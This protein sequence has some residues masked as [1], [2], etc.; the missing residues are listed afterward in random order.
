M[1]SDQLL[2]LLLTAV[3]MGTTLLLG[4][5]VISV[6]T[7]KMGELLL[8]IGVLRGSVQEMQRDLAEIVRIADRTSIGLQELSGFGL[9]FRQ[10]EREQLRLS[11]KLDM[12]SK[13]TD[14]LAGVLQLRDEVEREHQDEFKEIVEVSR[15][16][17]E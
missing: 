3:T 17:Q 9:Y 8:E 1:Q 5:F 11:E 12:I 4:V 7:R 2:L 10:M 13:V 6:H 14:S 16:L 15:S